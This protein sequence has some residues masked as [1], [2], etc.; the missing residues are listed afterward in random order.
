LNARKR[1]L[2]EPRTGPRSIKEI[3]VRKYP[4]ASLGPPIERL[5]AGVPALRHGRTD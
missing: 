5:A 1:R 4:S 2:T 3:H